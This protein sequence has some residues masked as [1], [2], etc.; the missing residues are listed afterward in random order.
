MREREKEK[1]KERDTKR[2]RGKIEKRDKQEREKES[3]GESPLRLS[4]KQRLPIESDA[5][6]RPPSWH[7]PVRLL[8]VRLLLPASM[9][10]CQGTPALA[11]RDTLTDLSVARGWWRWRQSCGEEGSVNAGYLARPKLPQLNSEDEPQLQPDRQVDHASGVLG[12]EERLEA[13]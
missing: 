4:I 5:E 11:G 6:Y 12:L 1:R 8:H 13:S 10:S 3:E 7:W 9:S 2:N